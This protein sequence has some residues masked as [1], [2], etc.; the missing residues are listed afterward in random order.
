M[1]LTLL[2]RVA[3]IFLDYWYGKQRK[4]LKLELDFGRELKRI[5]NK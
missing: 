2:Q 5:G 3:H 4:N 1:G